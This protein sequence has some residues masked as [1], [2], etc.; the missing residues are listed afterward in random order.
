MT[1]P[2]AQAPI[3]ALM[4]GNPSPDGQE[5][6]ARLQAVLNDPPIS[7]EARA[8]FRQELAHPKADERAFS[9]RTSC[10]V[11]LLAMKR[12]LRDRS[13]RVRAQAH[14]ELRKLRE[15]LDALP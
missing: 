3:S 14:E 4:V 15:E 13:K 2:E 5:W 7:P 8:R 6:T 1:H 11:A 10:G 9:L 12:G